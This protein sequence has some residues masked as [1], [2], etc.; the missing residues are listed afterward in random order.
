MRRTLLACLGLATLS[1]HADLRA[2]PR[3]LQPADLFEL[4]R[5]G[6]IA[7]SPART[8]AAI[9]IHRPSRWLDP[10]IP[11]A[12]IAVLD[13]ESGALSLYGTFYGQYRYGDAGSPQRAQVLRM[14]RFERG[15]YSAE[16][17]P[18]EEPERYRVNSPLWRVA[19]VQTPLML[20]H[21]ELDFVPVQQAE[22]FFTALYRQD[23]RVRLVRYAGEG[24]TIAGR[25]NVLDLWR[26]LEEWLAETMPA[27]A[28]VTLRRS[29]S[30]TMRR[31]QSP[32]PPHLPPNRPVRSPKSALPQL[33]SEPCAPTSSHSPPA[34]SPRSS[35]SPPAPWSPRSAR[36]RTARRSSRSETGG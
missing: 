3:L 14:L 19:S 6:R 28:R 9:E 29:Q 16:A 33:A 7:W 32:A 23:K 17:P 4:E 31:V 34:P 21:G 11:A 30:C 20:I 13:V 24:H 35:P 18:W 1:A 12:E 36:T 10:S 2:Q 5:I 26:R 25:A 27:G 8:R 15:V 22:E